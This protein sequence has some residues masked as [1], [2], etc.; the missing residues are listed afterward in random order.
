MRNRRK[1]QYVRRCEICPTIADCKT[2]F[3][4]YW[5]EKSHGGKGCC[6]PFTGWAKVEI[7]PPALPKMPRRPRRVTQQDLI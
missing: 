2:A 3:G 5:L 4:K 7:K 6:H 1:M